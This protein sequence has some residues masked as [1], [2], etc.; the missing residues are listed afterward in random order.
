M[1]KIWEEAKNILHNKCYLTALIITALCGYGFEITHPTIGIDDTD[2]NLYLDE[3]IQP[4]MGRW[5]MFSVNKIFRFSDFAPL[6]PELIGVI[7]FSFSAVLFCVLF[8]RLLG[9]KFDIRACIV[10]SC[11]FISNPIFAFCYRYYY[12]NGMEIAY[13]CCALALLYF[14][15][16]IH[17]PSLPGKEVGFSEC[18][19]RNYLISAVFA[20]IAAGC[21]E[22]FVIM[23]IVG[24]LV[25]LF[26]ED[27]DESRAFG[28]LCM[29]IL[30]AALTVLMCILMRAI[31]IPLITA[32]FGL[33]NGYLHL[34]ERG[35]SEMFVLFNGHEGLLELKML[36]KRFFVTY[37]LNA[38]VYL[39]I[40]VYEI[41][42]FVFGIASIIKAIK[43]KS[44]VH[45][46]LF[47][48]MIIAPFLLVILEAKLTFYRSTQYLPFFAAVGISYLYVC[49]MERLNN[50]DG[51]ENIK[52]HKQ[53]LVYITQ[54][55]CLI[56]IF[57]QSMELNKAFYMDYREYELSKEVLLN[58]AHDVESE[59]GRE[60]PLVFIGE[61]N[62]PYEYMK[63]F[64][65][66]YTSW[67][68]RTIEK[69][70]DVIDPHLKEKYWQPEGYCFINEGNLPMIRWALD[71]IDGTNMQMMR[72]LKLHGHNFSTI[73]DADEY[74]RIRTEGEA[75]KLP[76]YPESGYIK[77]MGEYILINL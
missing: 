29:R 34:N 41:S 42:C 10:F 32:V 40:T 52:R 18:A 59:Y 75:L 47:V 38:L 21:Y 72:F 50:A 7:L 17:R 35:F 44:L 64:Y 39:P 77:N 48:G 26:L 71:A 1:K 33:S 8:R 31:T 74:T 73:R 55:I 68:Y 70:T 49:L 66:P 4:Q 56:L 76:H 5:V 20:W 3:G 51:G 22:A 15:E 62:L 53:I 19:I 69:I 43:K 24:V 14:Y 2:V 37:H 9:A 61:F 57:N 16:G 65:V 11:L 60:K 36:I 12:H 6:M 54:F 58:V 27:S 30:M 45:P 23:F 28:R 25:V 63:D 13:N 46:L 67:Q